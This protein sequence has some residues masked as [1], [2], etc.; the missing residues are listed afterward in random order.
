MKEAEHKIKIEQMS[1]NFKSHE[2]KLKDKI[3]KAQDQ[4]NEMLQNNSS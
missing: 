2:Q 4:V 1:K 3:K